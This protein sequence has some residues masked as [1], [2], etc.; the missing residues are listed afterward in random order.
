MIKKSI[1][2]IAA[3]TARILPNSFKQAIYKIKPLARLIRGGLNRAAPTGLVEVRVA[4]GDLAGFTIQ[5]DMQIDKDYWL[6]TYEPELQSALRE[7]IPTGAVIFDVGANIG[8]VSLLLAK[9]TGVNGKVYAFEA[10]PSNVEQLRHNV[11]LNGME[12]RVTV[13]DRAVT[14]A[15][16]AVHFLVHASGGMGKVAGSAGRED[17]YQSEVTVAGISLDEFVHGEGNPPPQVVKM[18][19]EG[20]EVLALPGMRRVLAEARPLMLMELHG[21]EASRV[22]WETLTACGYTICWMRPGYP[23]ISSREAMGWKAYI[24]ARPKV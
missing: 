22:A 18:D 20:G 1:L 15:P 23:V 4:A 12:Q 2:D 17:R 6:G 8:Y 21:P 5:L 19:I 9:A 11:A 16:G 10:L 7:L 3:F 24:V 13:I 14:Q